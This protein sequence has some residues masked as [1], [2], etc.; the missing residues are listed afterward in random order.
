MALPDDKNAC[1]L[2]TTGQEGAT[3][4]LERIWLPSQLGGP[5]EQHINDLWLHWFW[6]CGVSQRDT[7]LLAPPPYDGSKSPCA[8]PGWHNSHDAG[9]TK[10]QILSGWKIK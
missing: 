9:E 3:D 7:K 5:A 6:L 8:E 1:L 4:D 2:S 10:Y